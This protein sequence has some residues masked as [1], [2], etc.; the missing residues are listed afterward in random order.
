MCFSR[1]D[2]KSLSFRQSENSC[3]LGSYAVAAYPFLKKNIID[4]FVGYCS[5]FSIRCNPEKSEEMYN[6]HF[7]QYLNDNNISGYQLIKNLHESSHIQIFCECRDKFTLN[8]INE[9]RIEIL[10]L[11]KEQHKSSMLLLFINNNNGFNFVNSMHS[12]TIGYDSLG[13]YMYDTTQGLVSNNVNRIF[14]ECNVGHT[15]LIEGL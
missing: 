5:H 6:N 8:F 2:F 12:V 9:N 10:K 13:Y 15:F 1:N 3:V 14:D 4:F 7:H 11:Q